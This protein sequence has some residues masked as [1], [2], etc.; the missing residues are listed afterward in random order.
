MNRTLT[1]VILSL[2]SLLLLTVHLTDDAVRGISPAGP[3]SMYAIVVA[4]LLLC[5]ILAHPHQT[6]GVVAMMLVGL[7]S[8]AMAPLHLRGARINDIAGGQGGFL[9]IW[10]LWALG[11]LGV[12]VLI[13]GAWELQLRRRSSHAG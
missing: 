2:L 13:L 5:A 11:I 6:I 3:E 8:V 7:F 1:L 9:F 10:T 4:G 12:A